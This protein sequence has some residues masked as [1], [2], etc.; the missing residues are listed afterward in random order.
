[1]TVRATVVRPA[2]RAD[3]TAWLE[4]RRALWPGA[5]E[6]HAREIEQFFTVG[7]RNLLAVLVAVDASNHP[8]GVAELSIRNCAEGCD[9]DRVA[10]LEGWYV[11][12]EARRQGVGRALVE[13]AEAWGRAQ[14]CREFASD[15]QID[16]A[17]SA[18]AHH[19]LGF[20]E[21]DRI[22]TFRKAL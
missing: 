6:D 5:D 20:T 13:A 16:N 2:T 3:A 17:V 15:T 10:Y 22:R 8:V 11:V 9:S 21:T 1:M 14:D 12:P 4:M 19:A 7:L 18:A